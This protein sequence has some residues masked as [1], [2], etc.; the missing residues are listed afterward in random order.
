MDAH[1]LFKPEPEPPSSLHGRAIENIRFIRQTMERAGSFTAVPGWGVLLMGITAF[2]ASFIAHRQA[3]P[4]LWLFTWLG[5]ALVAILIGGWTMDR[6]ARAADIALLQ[7]PGWRFF[8]S[9]AP[10]FMAGAILTT[11]LFRAGDYQLLPGV[12][13]LLYG[14]GAASAGAFSVPIVPVL[15]LA[16][17]ITGGLA[18]IA[19]PGWGDW[20]MAFGFG[21]L[22]IAFGYRIARRYGG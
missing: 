19:P 18:L 5:A 9:L 22:H 1:R 3:T 4:A 10:A 7:G 15:G 20:F 14:A 21:G 16:F 6:K 2:G 13:L 17:M 11:V 8:L 12:W